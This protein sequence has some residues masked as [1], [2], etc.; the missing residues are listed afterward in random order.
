ML[1]RESQVRRDCM[2]IVGSG[3]S[4]KGERLPMPAL[5]I[6]TEGLPW[7]SRILAQRSIRLGKSVMSHL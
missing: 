6:R 1:E 3:E 7:V 2:K 5:L 4:E